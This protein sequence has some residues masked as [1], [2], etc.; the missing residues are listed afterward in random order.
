[1]IR[2]DHISIG[3]ARLSDAPPVLVGELGGAPDSGGTADVFRWACWRYAGGGLLE[4]IEPRGAEGFLHRFLARRGPGIHHVTFRVP[5]LR[6]ACDRAAAH[7]YRV[8]GY[9]DSDP[10]W[11][12]AYLHPKE[13]LGI[14]VQLVQSEGRSR[15]RPGAVPPGPPSPPPAVRV[16]GLRM[17]A[18]SAERARIQWE[19]ILGGASSAGGVGERVYRWPR[20][21]MHVAVALD[22]AADEGP[23]GIEVASDR[24]LGLREE[25]PHPVLGAAFLQR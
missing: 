1:M 21:P 9:D 16:L 24:A 20:S 10:R 14:V 8:V 18:R 5:S 22:P 19:A 7:G 3:A 17:R 4:V 15:P 11:A 23:L 12:T 25:G 6:E 13:A 2:L